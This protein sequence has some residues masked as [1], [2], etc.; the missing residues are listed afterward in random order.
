MDKLYIS[1]IP[2]RPKYVAG[3]VPADAY[4]GNAIPIT[5]TFGSRTLPNPSGY[6]SLGRPLYPV[7]LVPPALYPPTYVA[8][9]SIYAIPVRTG[10]I[11]PKSAVS[12]TIKPSPS[13]KLELN[14]PPGLD[15]WRSVEDPINHSISKIDLPQNSPS[16]DKAIQFDVNFLN[17]CLI[18]H[19]GHTTDSAMISIKETMFESLARADTPADIVCVID[20][21][22][23]MKG[24]KLDKV[25][26]TLNFLLTVAQKSRI[27]L[28][29][30]NQSSMMG[31]NFK[32]VNTANLE[33]IKAV[34]SCINAKGNTNI[35]EG[36]RQAQFLINKRKSKNP[37]ATMLL[38][39]DGMHNQGPISNTILFGNESASSSDYSVHCF[40]YGDDHDASLMKSI[41]EHKGGNYYF[42]NHA[43]KVAECFG[44]C[45]GI[46]T[47]IIATNAVVKIQL[48]PSKEFPQVTIAKL[49]GPSWKKINNTEAVISL[50]DLY[51]GFSK[52]FIMDV[53]FNGKGGQSVTK[54][55]KIVALKATFQ[56]TQ[57]G[58]STPTCL[59][60]EVLRNVFPASSGTQVD[61]DVNIFTNL[62]R[63][64]GAEAI[65]EANQLKRQGQTKVALFKLEEMKSKITGNSYL[66]NNQLATE[67]A[68]NINQIA[69]MLRNDMEGRANAHK[70]ENIMAQQMN[71]FMN[72]N[73]A[74]QFGQCY[75]QKRNQASMVAKARA[76]Q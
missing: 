58:Q 59:K 65:E 36:V 31:M 45:L 38:L 13:T 25:K 10:Y 34:I 57:L 7:K 66:R 12:K 18:Q 68:G 49:Y 41:A 64:Q 14:L 27:A 4:L 30:F 75:F 37:V 22:G 74:P 62:V 8:N 61:Q 5:D 29:I 71:I 43:A 9:P 70:T 40:G 1:A 44:D 6:D 52:D 26:Q 39:T 19:P 73:S 51:A 42:V 20:V 48:I 28:V 35:I 24:E 2:A 47:S 54:N 55:T 17:S 46:V 16:L 63:V 69:G 76:Y 72:Q 32:S 67:L 3:Y 53:V 15:A 33:K 60:K 23:S 21:S 11:A 56:C 50:K